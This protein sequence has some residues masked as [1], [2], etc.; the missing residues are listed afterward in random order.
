ML[1]KDYPVVLPDYIL[2]LEELSPENCLFFD[3]ETT[4]LSGRPLI[5][6]FLARYFM[7]MKPGFTGSGSARSPAKKKKY[8]SLFPNFSPQKNCC[9]TI[10]EPPLMFLT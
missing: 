5:F 7:K 8:F 10:T 3:I 9:S 1:L 4:G 2:T 6:I